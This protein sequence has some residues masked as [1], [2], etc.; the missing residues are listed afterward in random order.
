MAKSPATPPPASA[1]APYA[2]PRE[3]LAALTEC[4][5]LLVERHLLVQASRYNPD[6]SAQP[7][8]SVGAAEVVR[9]LSGQAPPGELLA[10]SSA[11]EELVNKRWKEAIARIEAARAAG[12]PAPFLTL[13]RACHLG[14][15]EARVVAVLLAPEVDPDME[16]VFTFAYD[17]FTKKR[18]D[19]SFLCQLVGGG[20]DD[21]RERVRRALGPGGVLRRSRVVVIAH[22]HGAEAAPFALRAVRLAD[23][24][25]DHLRGDDRLDE[26]LEGFC[27]VPPELPRLSEVVV[28]PAVLTAV[29]RSL[30]LGEPAPDPND[31]S[32]PRP[33]RLLV[34]GPPGTGKT[35]LIEAVCQDAK[36]PILRV[37]L[38]LLLAD[39][40]NM[41]DRFSA[42]LREAA[43]RGAL[44]LF[45]GGGEI[46][47]ERVPR[48]TAERLG[49]LLREVDAPVVITAHERPE[50][51]APNIPSLGE[52]E[53]P[54]PT[55]AERLELWRRSVPTRTPLG[56]PEDLE[57]VASRYSFGGGS[58]L[59]AAQRASSKAWLRSPDAPLI[60]LEDLGEAARLM[61]SHRLGT[62]A[63]RIPPGFTWEDLVL[64]EDTLERIR[65]VVRFARHRTYLL[66][67]W[68]FSKKLP[69]GRGVSAIMAGPPGTGKTMVAQLLAR[70]LGYDLFRIDLAQIV[71]KY[72]GETEKNLARVF[73][74]AQNSH[75]ILFFDEADALFAKRTEVKSS[76][77][78]Y[79]NLEVNYLLQR[80]ETYDGVTLLATNLQ[81]GMDEAFKRRVRFSVE[82][83]MPEPDVRKKLWKSMFPPQTPLADDIDW[84]LLAKKYEMA[85]GHIKKVAIRAALMAVDRGAHVPIGNAD[86]Q[87]AARLEYREM[88]RMISG[89]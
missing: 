77:D 29:Q 34:F 47:S 24:V 75:A 45:Q 11:A 39:P 49:D 60:T 32:A 73:D 69:Y 53:L 9:T 70:E 78:R 67:S 79:A 35:M 4:V 21:A 74:E 71:N 2:N 48:T 13:M 86:L 85:G 89:S 40:E 38:P 26:A 55:M 15:I 59:R 27:R 83:E 64:P 30:R 19:V 42:L 80:M 22:G 1:P 6:G 63:Q 23:R 36:K 31:A 37:D 10:R 54:L 12:Q 44:L 72:I 17:D 16:R 5:R 57:V 41:M 25:V 7:R 87:L 76:V 81:Q 61:L 66:E 50:W 52:V 88:G 8:F 65:E 28:D 62:M 68:G 33:A 3:Q 14:D 20:S 51:L 84:D 46:G 18:P 43:L 56:N 58:I 82:F